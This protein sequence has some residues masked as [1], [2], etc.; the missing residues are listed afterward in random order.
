MN[1]DAALHMRKRRSIKL[2]TS[3]DGGDKGISIKSPGV[4]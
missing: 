4:G 1:G 2:L 3:F